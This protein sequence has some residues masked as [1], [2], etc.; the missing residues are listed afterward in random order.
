MAEPNFHSQ[1]G[2]VQGDVWE[3]TEVYTA[4]M[5]T[6]ETHRFVFGD[7]IVRPEDVRTLAEIAVDQ[8]SHS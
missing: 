8:V 5:S 1:G 6:K 2:E 7:I 3:L 4:T